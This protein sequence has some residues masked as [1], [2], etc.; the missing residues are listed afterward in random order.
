MQSILAHTIIRLCFIILV[1]IG[2][3]ACNNTEQKR[4]DW[5]VKARDQYKQYDIGGARKSVESAVKLTHNDSVALLAIAEE[6]SRLGDTPN[7]IKIYRNIIRLD[8]S[9]IQALIKL[10]QLYLEVNQKE[11]AN[12]LAEQALALNQASNPAILLKAGILSAQNKIDEALAMTESLLEKFPQDLSAQMLRAGLAAKKNQIDVAV[13]SLQA[14]I[15]KHPDNLAPQLMLSELY[16][17]AGD[18]D[19]AID[20]T[21]NLIKNNPK[22]SSYRLRLV[23]LYLANKNLKYAEETLRNSIT[24]FPAEASLKLEL[25]K[26]I[27]D[28]ISPESA[29]AE[30]IP[31][32]EQ[33]PSDYLLR[34]VL[35][36]LYS[37][38]DQTK[39]AEETLIEAVEEITGGMSAV[40]VRNRLAELYIAKN[41]LKDAKILIDRNLTEYPQDNETL[42]NWVRINLAEKQYDQA[43]SVLNSLLADDE[44]NLVALNLISQTYLA[45]GNNELAEVNLR[46]IVSIAPDDERARLL[47]IGLLIEKHE[48]E[49]VKTEFNQLFKLKPNSRSGL[50]A[51]VNYL[52][53]LR[54]G[55]EARNL[56]IQIQKIYPDNADGYYLEAISYQAE[57]K[58]KQSIEPLIIALKKQ[59]H[60]VESLQK[61]IEAYQ[62]LN[63][64]DKAIK[65]LREITK[66]DS[67][68]FIAYSML[69]NVYRKN[70]KLDTALQTDQKALSIRPC[71]RESFQNTIRILQRQGKSEKARAMLDK[72][73]HE[74][75]FSDEMFS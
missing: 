72:G 26:Y 40:K 45:L 27:S 58:Y 12:N 22:Q 52:I 30:L 60:A 24:D 29:I 39:A 14:S 33:Y 70:G 8:P 17:Q 73:K 37:Q 55:D 20:L 54:Q 38:I 65:F 62:N 44:L 47:L 51:L 19:K 6:V 28:Y 69:A 71:W 7:A 36:Q 53:V 50:S 16:F 23:K 4:R 56:A 5:L 41:N 57:N 43:L 61:L 67:Q 3:I 75:G 9:N 25:I 68:H 2:L 63:R 64:P 10:G 46:K 66:K 31:M 59:P 74:C 21:Q 11:E 49:A 35:V 48:G 13:T 1:T 42:L 15:N 34:L 18:I 32:I